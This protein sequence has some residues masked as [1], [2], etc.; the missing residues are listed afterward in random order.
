MN[1]KSVFEISSFVFANQ[2]T[3][4]TS[5]VKQ[6]DSINSNSPTPQNISNLKN[7]RSHR[8]IILLPNFIHNRN[9]DVCFLTEFI[10]EEEGGGPFGREGVFDDCC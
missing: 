8:L 9:I 7:R 4:F 5:S 3:T 1:H 10:I 6:T 2:T